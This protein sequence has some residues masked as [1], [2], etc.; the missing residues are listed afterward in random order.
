MNSNSK[1]WKQTAEL[2]M[3][4]YSANRKMQFW[5]ELTASRA[6]TAFKGV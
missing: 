5:K 2:M 6:V 1:W 4:H 3:F